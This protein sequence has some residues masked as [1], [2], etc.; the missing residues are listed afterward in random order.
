MFKD[1]RLAVTGV[2]F[3]AG[4]APFQSNITL[5]SAGVKDLELVLDE[6]RKGYLQGEY[7]KGLASQLA[8]YPAFAALDWN[9]KGAVASIELGTMRLAMAE[10][11]GLV[12]AELTG[13]VKGLTQACGQAPFPQEGV[14][15]TLYSQVLTE[16]FRKAYETAV[17]ED[18]TYSSDNWTIPLFGYS[19]VE[20][21]LV[22]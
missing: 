6:F 3:E 18:R 1:G 13:L 22:S 5:P 20:L 2:A 21:S 12:R 8:L 17:F 15:L 7:L 4:S 19:C 10:D 14:G 16:S 9:I 11:S